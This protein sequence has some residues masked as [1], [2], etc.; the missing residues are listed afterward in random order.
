M[1]WKN[2]LTVSIIMIMAFGAQQYFSHAEKII[3]NK[4]FSSFPTQIGQW[5]GEE[6]HFDAE[7]YKVLGADDSFYANYH[8]NQGRWINLFIGFYQ[9]QSEGELIHSPKNCMPG[10]GWNILDSEIVPIKLK[11]SLDES[12]KVIKLVL[13]KGESRQIS[14]Y[15]YQSRGRIISSEYVQKIYLVWDSITRNRTDGAFVRLITPVNSSDKETTV[16]LEKFIQDLFPILTNYI[17]S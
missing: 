16:I 1:L 3:P 17:P 7:V 5:R 6:E 4:P 9:S 15:W 13:Q 14:Y 2:T 8:D 11:G 12:I 10:G